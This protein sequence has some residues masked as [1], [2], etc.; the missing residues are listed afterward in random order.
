MGYTIIRS[1]QEV[2][3]ENLSIDAST[4][5]GSTDLGPPG[6]AVQNFDVTYEAGATG[7]NP[8]PGDE[9]LLVFKS[10]GTAELGDVSWDYLGSYGDPTATPGELTTVGLTLTPDWCLV[11][12]LDGG[13][14][15]YF[16]AITLGALQKG[17]TTTVPIG[18]LLTEPVHTLSVEYGGNVLLLPLL[19]YDAAFVPIPEPASAVLLALGLVGLTWCGSKRPCRR[20]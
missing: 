17:D 1:P 15:R 11:S 12:V 8:S 20:I 9:L 4:V 16:P 19:Y 3:G 7:P 18:F 2:L 6:Q 10:F 13:Q 14:T 5:P